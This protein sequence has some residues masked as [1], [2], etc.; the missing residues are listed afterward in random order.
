MTAHFIEQS[1]AYSKGGL[2]DYVNQ[3]PSG[4]PFWRRF[5]DSDSAR[6][7]APDLSIKF[8]MAILDNCIRADIPN[9]LAAPLLDGRKASETTSGMDMIADNVAT[10]ACETCEFHCIDVKKCAL[11]KIEHSRL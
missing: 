9:V 4:P 1:T 2:A 5:G 6:V 7:A 11:A 8:V 3:C 10:T